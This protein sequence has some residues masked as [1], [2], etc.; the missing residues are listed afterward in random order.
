MSVKKLNTAPLNSVESIELLAKYHALLLKNA[1]K[2]GHTGEELY[3]RELNFA[4]YPKL[5]IIGL[6]PNSPNPFLIQYIPDPNTP[7]YKLECNFVNYSLENIN[8]CL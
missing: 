8:M 4:R 5:R 2:Y 6:I 3:G 7:D 1:S